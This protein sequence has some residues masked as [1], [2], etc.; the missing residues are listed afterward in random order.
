MKTKTNCHV[1]RSGGG[2]FTLIELLVVIAI[3]AILAAM[4]LPALSNAKARAN[5][6]SCL[7]NLRQMGISIFIYASDYQDKL[8]PAQWNPD[9]TPPNPA[10]FRS[11]LMYWLGSA[12]GV[13][14]QP[15]NAVNLGLL[16]AGNYLRS[17]GTFYCP[18]LRQS[19]SH[20]I[21]FEKKYFESP[22]VPWPMYAVQQQVNMTYCY[23]PLSDVA[24]NA[25]DASNG[26]YR[27]ALKQ[28]ELRSNRALTTELIFTWNSLA[29]V[30]GTKPRGV[31]VVWGD[32]HVTFSTTAA[33]FAPALWG[34]T[35]DSWTTTQVPGG[36]NENFRTIIS[37]LRP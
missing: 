13:A 34:P 6:I 22:T 21:D 17:A 28:V 31:N 36:N 11:Y 37:L 23:Y 5:Q 4:L 32:G 3:I 15:D 7:N 33:A 12:N 16:H 18:S 35:D 2:G 24:N 14:A 27:N 29:H 30:S 19:S 10:P 9:R 20:Q 25:S 8:P 1:I 26:W